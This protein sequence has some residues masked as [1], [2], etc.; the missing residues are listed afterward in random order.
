MKYLLFLGAFA[1]NEGPLAPFI[2]LSSESSES[3]KYLQDESGTE[4]RLA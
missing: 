3:D 4:L 1:L 2:S